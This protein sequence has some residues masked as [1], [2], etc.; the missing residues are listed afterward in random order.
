MGEFTHGTAQAE[1]AA[2]RRRC[3]PERARPT[4]IFRIGHEPF[5]VSRERRAC[6]HNAGWP[7]AQDVVSSSHSFDHGRRVTLLY[8]CRMAED[9]GRSPREWA[10]PCFTRAEVLTRIPAA[11]AA[12][13]LPGTP[14]FGLSCPVDAAISAACARR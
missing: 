1:P 4:R 3:P 10:M 8:V 6:T 7:I 9:V 12:D 13:V 11:V 5:R 14:D 2:S